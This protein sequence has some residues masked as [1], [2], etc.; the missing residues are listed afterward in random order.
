MTGDR[1]A[2]KRFL[3]HLPVEITGVNESGG[4]F[5][6]MSRIEDAGGLGCCFSLQNAV[7]Q[8]AILAIEPLGPDGENLE[9]EHPRLLVII[10]AEPKGDRLM[11]GARSL[12]E[13]ELTNS[14]CST[15]RFHSKGS[16]K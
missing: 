1:R 8:G 3:L 14:R 5:V 2:D 9:D 16:A 12:L 15:N 13:G 7:Q 4:Q 6:E 10:W 11:V